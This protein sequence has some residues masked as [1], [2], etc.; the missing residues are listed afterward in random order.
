VFPVGLPAE[1]GRFG[2]GQPSAARGR[3]EIV[4]ISAILNFQESSKKKMEQDSG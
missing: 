1:A 4:S 3:N 2:H